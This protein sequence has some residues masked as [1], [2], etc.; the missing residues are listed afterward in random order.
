MI[1][2]PIVAVAAAGTAYSTAVVAK[3]VVVAVARQLNETTRTTSKYHEVL[4]RELVHF[5][6]FKIRFQ[7]LTLA[8]ATKICY[9]RRRRD[10]AGP[11]IVVA[12]PPAQRH[13]PNIRPERSNRKHSRL[14][15]RKKRRKSRS[16]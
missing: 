14:D 11:W 12:P 3:A 16:F 13:I 4:V 2:R 5:N 9:Q 10:P 8:Y 1:G 7:F 6:Q 15:L